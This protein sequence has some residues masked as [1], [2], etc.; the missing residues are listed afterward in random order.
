MCIV[1]RQSKR[2]VRNSIGWR[3]GI[4]F[5]SAQGKLTGLIFDLRSESRTSSTNSK[6]PMKGAFDSVAGL[7]ISGWNSF[8]EW[9]WELNRVFTAMQ[10]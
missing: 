3:A 2:V 5:D 10:L 6:A 7:L 1:K 8:L 9:L 4:P